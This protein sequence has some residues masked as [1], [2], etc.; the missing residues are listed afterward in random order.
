MGRH[1]TAIT[2]ARMATNRVAGAKPQPCLRQAAAH[3]ARGARGRASWKDG[4]Q[5]FSARLG[6]DQ[7][8]MLARSGYVQGQYLSRDQRQ[9]ED[10]YRTSWLVGRMVNVVA[11][12][13]VRGGI[14]IRAQWGA[15]DAGKAD[16]LLREHRRTGCPGRLSDAVKWA[17]LYGG[18]LAVL[19]ID[20]DDLA[21]PLEIDSICRGSFRGLYVLDRWQVTPGTEMIEDIGPMLGY[22]AYYTINSQGGLSGQQ[23]HHSRALRFIGVELPYQQ[24]LSENHWGASVVEQAYDRMLAYDSATQGSANLLYKSFLRVI[25]VEGL[26][27]ILAQGGKAEQALVRQFEMIRRMQSNEGITLLDKNDTFTTAGFSFSGMYDAMLAFA[28][29]IAGATGI[30]LVRLLGQSPKG[31]STG[32]SD[33]R[34]YYDTIATLQDDDLRPALDVIFAVLS[35]SLW[36]E[37]LPEGFSFEFENLLQP[38]E[39]DKAQIATADAQAVAALTQG[40]IIAPAQALAALRDGARLTGRFAN[41]SDADI[42]AVQKAEQAPEIPELGGGMPKIEG[43][44]TPTPQEISLNGAQVTSMVQIVSQVAAGLLPRGSAVQMLLAAF[45]LTGEQAEKIMGDVGK[46]FSIPPEQAGGQM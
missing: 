34:T 42:D 9:L 41:I 31:F 40:G 8:N 15:E 23:V 2:A 25:G 26:R 7:D 46:G 30:P 21:E 19:L 43:A 13:M 16:E 6:L 29:Q 27:A 11:E 4:F 44:D 33:L 36:G 10:M 28:E 37:P 5:N 38:S 12:D 22:P 32:E 20:G 35:R 39:M 45:P 24:R 1:T 18:A 17:R 3:P 14:D